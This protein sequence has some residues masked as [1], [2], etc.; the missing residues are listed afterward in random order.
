M[1]ESYMIKLAKAW[2]KVIKAG[3]QP[4]GE[5]REELIDNMEDIA[6]IKAM[7]YALAELM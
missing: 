2:A 6:Q 4:H 7:A 5:L 3:K 1:K